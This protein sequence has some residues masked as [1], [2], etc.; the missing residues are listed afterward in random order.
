M[1]KGVL[2]KLARVLS[3]LVIGVAIWFWYGQLGDVLELLEMAG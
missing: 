1:N 2:D 3:I